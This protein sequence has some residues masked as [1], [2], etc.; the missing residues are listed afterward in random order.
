VFALAYA[1]GGYDP[2]TRSVVALAV[3][4]AIGL[5]LVFR[6]IPL[7]PPP[8]AA[9]V[10]GALLAGY[11][12]LALASTAWSP[13]AEDAFAE[14][15]RAT[16]LLG[17]F[18]L[19]VVGSRRNT[20][21]AWLDGLAAGVVG[22]AIV[23]LTSRFFPASFGSRGLAD[24][25][26]SF[27]VR[28]TF[29][30][31]YWN[32]LAILCA[33]SVPLLLRRA[34]TD[35]HPVVRG[36][37]VAPL[38]A[39]AAVI[40]LASSRGGVATAAT[41]AL[42][43]VLLTPRRWPAA[44]SLLVG[45]A[46]SAAAVLVLHER[47]ELVN[48]PLDAPVVDDQGRTAAL[49]VVLVCAACGA[50]Y[51]ALAA[52]SSRVD[53][54]PALGRAAAALAALVAV[55]AVVAFDPVARF[56]EFRE[57]PSSSPTEDFVQRHLTSAGGSGRWQFWTAAADQW[58]E[59][60]LAGEGAGSYESWWAREGSLS[61]F[62][63]DAHS[64]Y[65][66]TLGELGVLG[67]VLLA[68]ALLVA[69]GEGV[70]RTRAGP[71]DSRSAAAAAAALVAAFAIA[72]AIDWMWELT[73][74][75]AVAMLALGLLVGPATAASELRPRPPAAV[76]VAVVAVAWVIVCA[77]ALALLSQVQLERSDRA[78]ADGD[79]AAALRHAR[80]AQSIQP[81]AAAPHLQ[82]AL[83][84][85]RVGRLARAQRAL[86]DAIDRDGANWRLWLTRSRIETK[87]GEVTAARRSLA[88]ARSLNPRS[89]IFADP[90]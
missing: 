22:V 8:K 81:W 57:P 79:A 85:E 67:L 29:P 42:A 31:G 17:I 1:N 87:A 40:F 55:G 11:A 38:P 41:G 61:L 73:V 51:G 3:W 52:G 30:V 9:V 4:W 65:L 6:L 18:V 37:A 71:V 44:F 69:L 72:A 21:P 49:L 26:P 86:D 75:S 66:E 68:G 82:E 13:S 27:H 89:P 77:Q 63:R 62:V 16:L 23:A 80:A 56:E 45:G 47:D 84:E 5:G 36:L 39:L 7:S 28:L 43:F 78:A 24:F 46:G 54:P 50:L 10:V 58:R 64:L 90:S 70:R 19:G 14:F 53:A 48:G 32:G 83:V 2:S 15:N 12:A 88:R 76:G 20:L 34:V 25:L 33:L 74:V 35:A 59:H 60:R